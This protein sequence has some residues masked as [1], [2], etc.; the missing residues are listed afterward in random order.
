MNARFPK[1]ERLHG[2]I[3]IQNLFKQAFIEKYPLRLSYIRTESEHSSVLIS[4]PKRKI[5]LAVNRNTIKRRI[6]EVYR[7]HKLNNGHNYHFGFVYTSHKI[8]S[9]ANIEVALISLLNKVNS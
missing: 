5:S 3:D 9:Y 7:T 1:K 2:E 8:E 4:V 6:R